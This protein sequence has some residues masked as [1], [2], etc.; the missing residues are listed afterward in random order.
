[1]TDLSTIPLPALCAEVSRREKALEADLAAIKSWRE[2]SPVSTACAACGHDTVATVAGKFGVAVADIM[3]RKRTPKVSRARQVA[4]A[5]MHHAGFSLCE[6]GRFFER[7]HGTV[8]HA[9][10]TVKAKH[11]PP[12]GQP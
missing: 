2:P 6:I 9:I 1:M 12:D 4:M 7:D 10:K 8:M 3:G 11:S 5:G